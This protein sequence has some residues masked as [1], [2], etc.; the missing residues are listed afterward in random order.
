MPRPPLPAAALPLLLAGLLLP[1]PARPE[2][3]PP[4]PAPPARAPEPAAGPLDPPETVEQAW[5]RMEAFRRAPLHGPGALARRR[6]RLRTLAGQVAGMEAAR[7]AAGEDLHR[8]A[9][10]LV[11]GG[12]PAEAL[13]AATRYLAGRG[14]APLPSEGPA[15]SLRVRALGE[16]G[17]FEEAAE[18]CAAWFEADPAP[19]EAPAALRALG[20]SLV[21]AGRVEAALPRYRDALARLPRPLPP[22]SGELVQALVETLVALGRTEEALRTL[23]AAEEAARGERDVARR[24][25][26]VRFRA[27]LTGTP[28]P[29]PRVE[30]WVGSPAPDPASL[31]GRVVAWHFFAWW[32]EVRLEDLEAWAGMARAEA[33]RGFLLFPV[34]RIA[35]WVP[36]KGVFA[37]DRRKDEEVADILALV[38]ARGWPGTFAAAS[39]AAVSFGDLQVR[40]LPFDVVVGRDGRVR[41]AQAGD[42]AG[43]ALARFAAARALAE[44]VPAEAPRPEDPPGDGDR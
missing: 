11:E 40:S 4:P 27:E 33:A 35:G 13:D 22:G 31:R 39:G 10:I 28:F 6:E 25:E 7:A 42:A 44:P 41:L 43:A 34:T 2:E 19:P 30:T 8:V 9:V 26:A 32:M 14:E 15:R 20:D 16:L 21:L 5:L 24:L 17:R 36:A 37:P 18:A 3:P 1:S 12:R 23:A 38:R 29:P